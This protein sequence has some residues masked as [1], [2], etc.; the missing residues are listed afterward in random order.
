MS[1]DRGNRVNGRLLPKKP[2]FPSG[3]SNTS[4]RAQ[5]RQD[6]SPKQ[7][8]NRKPT[9]SHSLTKNERKN[10]IIRDEIHDWSSSSACCNPPMTKKTNK[11]VNMNHLLQ[12]TVINRPQHKQST[13]NYQFH[14]KKYTKRPPINYVRT[15]CQTLLRKDNLATPSTDQL[16]TDPNMYIEWDQCIGALKFYI[17]CDKDAHTCAICLSDLPI[18]PRSTRCGHVFCFPCILHH[19]SVILDTSEHKTSAWHKCP[20]CHKEILKRKLKPTTITYVSST[21]DVGSTSEFHLVTR[22]K[23]SIFANATQHDLSLDDNESLSLEETSFGFISTE[24]EL[25]I[26][27]TDL[28]QLA[29]ELLTAETS[30]APFLKE[31]MQ[32]TQLDIDTITTNNTI[33]TPTN[34]TVIKTLPITDRNIE[35]CVR[36]YQMH[37]RRVFIHPLTYRC[38]LEEFGATNI[39]NDI[40]GKIIDVET[41]QLFPDNLSR[42]KFL[43]HLP[44]GTTVQFVELQLNTIRSNGLPVKFREE[45][46]AKVKFAI[47][48]RKK[49]RREKQRLE[50]QY[51]RKL[52]HEELEG[53]YVYDESDFPME[54]EDSRHSEC[55]DEP[56]LIT[57]NQTGSFGFAAKLST[58]PSNSKSG[59]FGF[60]A[61]MRSTS[62]QKSPSPPPS[63]AV[64]HIKQRKSKKKNK[65]K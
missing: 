34:Q 26:L 55:N 50:N 41:F 58:T 65:R 24:Y 38:L 28:T 27:T 53:M 10:Q 59:T 57:P 43:N 30:E 40:E 48:K 61:Q 13:L 25:K 42:F 39:P 6:T 16:N 63:C 19:F 44:I 9:N 32:L 49:F 11:K 15:K 8:P 20:I 4:R 12:C 52:L 62:R 46:M 21:L 14:N 3:N 37:N 35:D 56:V 22:R 18:A 17:S 54:H 64:L 36:Y 5:N 60:A 23:G 33:K 51:E 2:Q 31:A 29:N 47:D 45:V 1:S 7:Y